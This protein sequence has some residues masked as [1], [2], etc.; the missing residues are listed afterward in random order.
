MPL[1]K[2]HLPARKTLPHATPP[3]VTADHIFFITICCCSRA[4][5]QL[6]HS[7]VA[8]DLFESVEF[9]QARGDWFV[10]LLLLMPDHLHGLMSFSRDADMKRII[11]QWKERTAKKSGVHWQRDFFDH[12]LR[13]DE[14]YEEK[15][16]YVRM[17]P[18]RKGL[19]VS[20]EKWPFVWEPDGKHLFH[21]SGGPS[22]PALP[23]DSER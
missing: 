12:R 18:V 19:V 16:H 14:S 5:N 15:A 17:N 8:A 11:A 10:H 2:T 1:Q 20:A 22:G 23:S 13:R 3:W 9:R 21:R 6:C 7:A 4:G